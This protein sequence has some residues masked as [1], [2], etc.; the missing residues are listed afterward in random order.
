[1]GH[2][3]GGMAARFVCCFVYELY[4]TCADP[5][6]RDFVQSKVA[7]NTK[8]QKLQPICVA[9]RFS[10]FIWAKGLDISLEKMNPAELNTELGLLLKEAQKENGEMYEPDSLPQC[11]ELSPGK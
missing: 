3:K 1:M 9:R 6:L 8:L 10:E 2:H 5:D 11:T 7:T 4:M